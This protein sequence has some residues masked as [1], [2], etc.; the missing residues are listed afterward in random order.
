M[1]MVSDAEWAQYQQW[2]TGGQ[3]PVAQAAQPAQQQP[4]PRAQALQ[5]ATAGAWS[6]PAAPAQQNA[7]GRPL[8]APRP[9]PSGTT[10][11][12]P[13]QP[14]NNEA[15]RNAMMGAIGAAY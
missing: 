12:T 10:P 8:G 3:Q 13:A 2:K 4:D 9:Q 15:R 1:P 11:T 7:M 6:A 5:Q 14:D